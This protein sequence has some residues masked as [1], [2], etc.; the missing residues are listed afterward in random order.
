V[1]PRAN[2]PQEKAFYAAIAGGL[3]AKAFK[4]ANR[5][6]A[7]QISRGNHDDTGSWLRRLSYTLFLQDSIGFTYTM[8]GRHHAA[9]QCLDKAG[10]IFEAIPDKAQLVGTL[11]HCSL[12]SER[13]CEWRAA[14]SAARR[15]IR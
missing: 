4:I 8:M 7:S 6:A 9:Q 15:V 3:I 2:D 11:L 14:Q 12:L 13:R 10:R 5:T 1:H